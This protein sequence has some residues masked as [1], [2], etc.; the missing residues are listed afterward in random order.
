MTTD[1]APGLKYE[2]LAEGVVR[3]IITG[4]L[5]AERVG[6]LWTRVVDAIVESKPPRVDVDAHDMDSC[7]GAGIALLQELKD[8]QEN[9]GREFRIEGL[10]RE[11]AELM[12]LFEIGPAVE[13]ERRSPAV[14]R[15]FEAIGRGDSI[16]W[17]TCT[18]GSA[19]PARR[20]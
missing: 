4:R 1:T 2:T 15:F 11:L 19:S 20:P 3:L 18:P 13:S 8:R 10:R 7:D 9:A 14:V 5:D 6:S 16:S 12:S 17:G